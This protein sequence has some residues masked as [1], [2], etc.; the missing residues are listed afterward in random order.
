MTVL[1]PIIEF[2]IQFQAVNASPILPVEPFNLHADKDAHILC[3]KL[4]GA[5]LIL[6]KTFDINLDFAQVGGFHRQ[7]V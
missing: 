5:F 4:N 1:S 7:G 2:L 3:Q 6:L